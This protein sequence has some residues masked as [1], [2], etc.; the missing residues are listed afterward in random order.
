MSKRSFG[1]TILCVCGVLMTV[2]CD[3]EE[4]GNCKRRFKEEK[5]VELKAPLAN[6]STVR[7]QTNYGSITVK[8]ADVADCAVVAK[9]VVQSPVEAEVAELMQQ[10][11][12]ELEQAGDV[13]TVKADKPILKKNRSIGISYTITVPTQTNLECKTC[14][15]SLD[16]SDIAG[17]IVANTSYGSIECKNTI[18]K[19]QLDTSYGN[20]DCEEVLANDLKISTSYGDINV[21]CSQKTSSGMKV[22]ARTSYGSINFDSPTGFA[23]SVNLETSHGSIST[24]LP[25]TVKGKINKKRITGTVGQGD[26]NLVL[27]TSYGSINLK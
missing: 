8:G 5:V 15:G 6:N 20:V 4:F 21:I 16:F 12:I 22:S 3:I 27:R 23:G 18:G 10:V 11:K 17:D 1:L 19:M 9:I 2:G 24:D 14:Y 26:G 25:V 13:L 7:A